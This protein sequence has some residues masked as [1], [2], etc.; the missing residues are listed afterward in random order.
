MQHGNTTHQCTSKAQAR[1]QHKSNTT[2]VQ[3]ECN[4]STVPVKIQQGRIAVHHLSSTN[5]RAMFGWSAGQ[6]PLGRFGRTMHLFDNCPRSEKMP[7]PPPKC[8]GHDFPATFETLEQWSSPSQRE[9][10]TARGGGPTR[11]R[12]TFPFAR[13]IAPPPGGLAHVPLQRDRPFG[14]TATPS[15]EPAAKPA[16]PEHMVLLTGAHA[17]ES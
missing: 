2:P 6:A 16:R 3:H 7:E 14:A 5:S 12:C 9:V 13:C 8:S 17:G 10:K 11:P 1:H 4:A 15:A